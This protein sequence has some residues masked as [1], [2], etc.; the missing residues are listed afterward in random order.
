MNMEEIE[1]HIQTIPNGIYYGWAF[2]RGKVYKAVA[3]VGFNPYFNNKQK[4]CEPHLLDYEG[5]DFYEET[6]RFLVCGY[7]RNEA[8]FPSLE[9]LVAAIKNDIAV[10]AEKLDGS[11]WEAYGKT[12]LGW[13]TE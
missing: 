8:S 7:V 9:A 11:D 6:L 2:M 5:E 1:A 13:T 10:A 12:E 4:T 3:S